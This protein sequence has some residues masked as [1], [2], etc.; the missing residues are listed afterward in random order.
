MAAMA[1]IAVLGAGLTGLTTA[2]LLT[3]D[4]HRVAVLERDPV[5]PPGTAEEIWA[6]WERPA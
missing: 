2:L 1:D 6:G 5:R 3:S 4:G